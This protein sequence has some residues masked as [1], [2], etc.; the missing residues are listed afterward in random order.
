MEPQ[1]FFA[2]ENHKD[3]GIVDEDGKGQS[4][5]GLEGEDFSSDESS[6]TRG[7][8]FSRDRNVTEI[9]HEASQRSEVF[10]V[11]WQKRKNLVLGGVAR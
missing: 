9:C 10:R 5:N 11:S 4:R 7:V 2:K 1:S 6:T 8:H 3:G